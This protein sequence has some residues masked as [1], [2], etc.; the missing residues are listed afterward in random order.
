[1][2]GGIFRSASG[3]E[4]SEIGRSSTKPREREREKRG[5]RKT[6]NRED[7]APASLDLSPILN[8]PMTIL[9]IH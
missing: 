4:E 8:A 9:P 2:R 3:K 5:R 6:R 7:A 1:M